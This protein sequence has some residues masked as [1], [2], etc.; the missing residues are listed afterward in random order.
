[1]TPEL[2]PATRGC[3]ADARTWNYVVKLNTDP[4]YKRNTLFYVIRTFLKRPYLYQK[5]LSS[6]V[7]ECD[8]MGYT[9]LYKY[10][11]YKQLFNIF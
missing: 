2:Q 11:K 7:L 10:C 4:L 5:G 1:M 3:R 8:F 9:I 6:G